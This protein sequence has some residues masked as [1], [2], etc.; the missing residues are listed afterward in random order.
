LQGD[1][2]RHRLTLIILVCLIQGFTEPF[3]CGQDPIR[4]QLDRVDWQP[5]WAVAGAGYV[6][7]EVCAQCH[8]DIASTQKAGP[9]AHAL[10]LPADSLVLQQHPQ[11]TFSDGPYRYVIEHKGSEVSYSV[12]DGTNTISLPV[13]WAFGFGIGQV[14][15]TYLLSYKGSYY[16]SR[17]SFFNGV[18]GLDLTIGHSP[19]VPSSSQDALGRVVKP[20]ELRS[21]FGCHSTGGVTDGRLETD[22]LVPGI[23]CEGCHGPGAEH[24]D[25]AKRGRLRPPHIF[26]PATLAS[27][28]LV[29]FCGACHRTRAHV[30]AQGLKGILTVRFQPYRLTE[31]RCFKPRDGRISCLACHDPHQNARHEPAF[32]D[33]KCVACHSGSK[34]AGLIAHDTPASCTVASSRCTTCHMPK[35]MLAGPH[36]KFTDHKIRVVRLGDTFD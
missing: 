35:Y 25:A 2:A 27:G 13:S 19:V 18:Q 30:E 33:S 9:M 24:V 36:F 28:D 15:Q 34:D 1:G 31:S 21:C 10:A 29:K 20:E 4:K 11:L 22:K 17:V 32:Y 14:G 8:P 7:R 3:G 26:N 6:G 23:T 16:E 5:T 12:T